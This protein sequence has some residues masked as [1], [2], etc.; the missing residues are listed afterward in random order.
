MD[1]VQI[2]ERR[3]RCT[4]YAILG[5]TRKQLAVM[6]MTLFSALSTLAENHMERF[7]IIP[8]PTVSLKGRMVG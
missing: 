4:T 6:V 2:G 7:G 8:T 3:Q 1:C 5:N